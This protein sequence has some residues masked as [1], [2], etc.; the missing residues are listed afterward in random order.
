MV[1]S[2]EFC[3]DTWGEKARIMAI[4]RAEKKFDV[5]SPRV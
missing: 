5:L 2:S 1:T 3:R 4:D